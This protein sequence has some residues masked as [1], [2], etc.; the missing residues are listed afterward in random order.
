[1][2]GASNRGRCRNL[3]VATTILD[4]TVVGLIRTV[5]LDPGKLARC[6]EGGNRNDGRAALE[7][8]RIAEEI[9]TFNE[10]RRR[11]CEAYAKERMSA[12]EYIE[13][14]RTID[15]CIVRLR[16]KRDGLLN[17]ETGQVDVVS[18]SIQQFCAMA[19]ARF[20]ACADLDAKRAFL[21]DHVERIIFDH[22]K[23]TILGSLPLKRT[24]HGKLPFRIEGKIPKESRRRW[25]QDE[26]FGSWL[27][28]SARFD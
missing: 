25:P 3:C 18:A 12:E 7:L 17:T 8:A 20:E 13:A 19:Q 26:R 11:I 4:H 24:V 23:I 14:S 22:G 5:M 10:K 21:R 9:D 1:M 6:I 15:E 16:R 2:H 27:P 28:V